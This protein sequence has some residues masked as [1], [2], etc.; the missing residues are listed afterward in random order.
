MRKG[1]TIIEMFVTLAIIVLLISIIVPAIN[2]VKEEKE[3]K[4][5]PRRVSEHIVNLKKIVVD[6]YEIT[7]GT[8]ELRREE[9]SKFFERWTDLEPSLTTIDDSA[10]KITFIVRKKEAR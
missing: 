4:S 10:G 7:G 8:P 9:M 2:K 3:H 1:Y 5:E 6:A